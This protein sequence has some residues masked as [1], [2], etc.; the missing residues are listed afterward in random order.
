MS[1]GVLIDGTP[2]VGRLE[3]KYGT[4][5]AI[6]YSLIYTFIVFGI[7]NLIAAIFVENV[8]ESAKTRRALY[9]EQDQLRVALL[10][11]N[12][13]LRFAV[14]QGS[15]DESDVRRIISSRFQAVT[16]S[17]A[18]NL[19][20]SMSDDGLKSN[21]ISSGSRSMVSLVRSFRRGSTSS[22]SDDFFYLSEAQNVYELD[23]FITRRMFEKAIK[24]PYVLKLLDDLEIQINDR[25]ELFDVLD[26]DG[27]GSIDFSEL[28]SGLIKLRSVAADKADQVATTL[29]LR[30]VQSSLKRMAAEQESRHHQL[31]EH[32]HLHPWAPHRGRWHHWAACRVHINNHSRCCSQPCQALCLTR[33]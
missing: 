2:L 3:A 29:Y 8:L 28:V 23:G 19:S 11:R 32:L 24:D 30:S 22:S 27:G 26:A 14:H 13:L 4:I 12:L 5:F 6:L 9:E 7:F 16:T 17:P 21:A 18:R 15:G 1:D 31:L 20:V 10:L 25:S 33:K